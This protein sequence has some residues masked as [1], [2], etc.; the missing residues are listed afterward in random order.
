MVAELEL[1]SCCIHTQERCIMQS[2]VFLPKRSVSDKRS[3]G[4]VSGAVVEKVLLSL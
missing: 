3:A 4:T 1:N 2:H